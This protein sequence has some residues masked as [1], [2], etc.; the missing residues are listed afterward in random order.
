MAINFPIDNH[1]SGEYLERF[2]GMLVR[3]SDA[4]VTGPTYETC[5]FSIVSTE[6]SDNR[7]IRHQ[8]N[9]PGEY[10]V[11]VLNYSDVDCSGFPMVN[12]GDLVLSVQGPLTYHFDQFKIVIQEEI[13]LS[14]VPKEF[15]SIP[16]SPE[17]SGSQIT[18]ATFNLDNYFDSINDTGMDAE[19]TFSLTSISLKQRKL[20]YQISDILGCPTLLALQEVEKV[21][22]LQELVRL[23]EEPCGMEYR[24]DHLPTPD[25]RGSDLAFLVDPEHIHVIEVS[26][27]QTC[28]TIETG[29]LDPNVN[30]AQGYQPLFSRPPL[31]LD[32]WIDSQH[33]FILNNHLKSKRGENL[34]S[35]ERRIEQAMHIHT[36]IQSLTEDRGELAVIVVGD[37]NDYYNSQVMEILVGNGLLTSALETVPESEKYSYIFDGYSQ[38]IDWILVLPTMMQQIVDAQIWHVNADFHYKMSDTEE[39]DHLPYRA[40]DHD[41]PMITLQLDSNTELDNRD[42]YVA[43]TT[44]ALDEP[45]AFPQRRD[46]G[47]SDRGESFQNLVPSA[48]PSEQKRKVQSSP[49]DTESINLSNVDGSRSSVVII[50]IISILGM[51]LVYGFIRKLR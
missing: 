5:G 15:A 4:K 38:L 36:F 30:C 31:A 20:T 40:S 49:E 21:E 23:L 29:I 17:L 7:L 47:L 44:V 16:A 24:I 3:F 48:I 11:G 32:A 2:E 10:V 51:V 33:F 27:V 25:A 8:I 1:E 6:Q 46:D 43:T 37:F 45:T 42:G 12:F 28:T 19:P 39:P 22:L 13:S 34:S 9:S 26:Q 41:I 50:G 14:I 18:V 35:Q